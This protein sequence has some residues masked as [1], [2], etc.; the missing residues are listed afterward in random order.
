MS[1]LA[2]QM[3]LDRQK[4]EEYTTGKK[5]YYYDDEKNDGS[6]SLSVDGIKARLGDAD[7]QGREFAKKL[8]NHLYTEW[9]KFAA[10]AGLETSVFNLAK[11]LI[12]NI[13]LN[14]NH[15]VEVFKQAGV[16]LEKYVD[17]EAE[18]SKKEAEAKKPA[19]QS[20][21][22]Q[23]ATKTEESIIIN[24]KDDKVMSFFT[25]VAKYII[26]HNL[27]NGESKFGQILSRRMGL[28]SDEDSPRSGRVTKS[29]NE[30]TQKNDDVGEKIDGSIDRKRMLDVAQ[31]LGIKNN[32]ITNLEQLL[33]NDTRTF[34][35][36]SNADKFKKFFD[37]RFDQEDIKEFAKIGFAYL[38]SN[39]KNR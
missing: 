11:Y 5:R 39:G 22:S 24:E 35:P 28:D 31:A 17:D 38:C 6:Y 34:D 4:I 21:Q 20:Q 10:G 1:T 9:R 15:T 36:K 27:M 25:D 2:E 30:K 29:S 14:W 8:T 19:Q 32:H 18:L 26:N 12:N 7:A 16:D 33:Y 37:S 23:D 13:G 3:R